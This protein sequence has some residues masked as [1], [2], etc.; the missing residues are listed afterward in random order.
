[1]KVTVIRAFPL[2]LEICGLELAATNGEALP[3]FDAGAHIDV[4]IAPNLVRQY[5]LCNPHEKSGRYLIGV[6]RD[7]ASRGGSH[8]LHALRAGDEIDISAPRNHFPLAKGARHSILIAGGIGVTPILAMAEQLAQ[9]GAS[10]E[11]HYGTR[12]AEHMAFL[13]HLDAP[14]LKTPSRLYHDTADGT[15]PNLAASLATILAAPHPQDHVYVCGPA[16]LIDAV[17]QCAQTAGWAGANVHRE[18]FAAPVTAATT[19]DQGDAPFQIE[20]ARS[21]QRIDVAREQTIVDALATAGIEIATSCGEGVCGTCLT[22]VLGGEPAHRDAY[23]TP[24]EQAAND[25]IL[26]CCSRSRSPVLILD[27]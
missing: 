19:D 7:P 12:T 24:E 5:S 23:L 6:L 9:E 17:M 11:L 21:G 18:Y 1:M 25:Q 27:L 14:H 2:A 22:R 10:F 4:H 26:P 8:A 15:R 13:D 3:D 20:L 16:G